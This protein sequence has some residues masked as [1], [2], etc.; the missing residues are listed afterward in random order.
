M[1]IYLETNVTVSPKMACVYESRSNRKLVRVN[2]V[3]IVLVGVVTVGNL[4]LTNS[5]ENKSKQN[6]I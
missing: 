4:P 6:A 2:V 1:K 5:K 3:A